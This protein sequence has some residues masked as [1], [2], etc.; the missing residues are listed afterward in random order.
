MIDAHKLDALSIDTLMALKESVVQ[1]IVRKQRQTLRAGSEAEF[2]HPKLGRTV[3]IMIERINPKTIG[4]YEIDENG[5]HLR[6]KTWRVGPSI[7]KPVVK[8]EMAPIKI[9]GARD[10]P[11]TNAGW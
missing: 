9:G 8:K 7:L 6:K 3:R 10:T 1:A 2:Y 5:I 11:M 4:G